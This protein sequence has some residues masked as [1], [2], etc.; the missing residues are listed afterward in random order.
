M[1]S[2]SKQTDRT[3]H[4]EIKVGDL[5]LNPDAR[6]RNTPSTKFGKVTKITPKG[7]TIYFGSTE[8]ELHVHTWELLPYKSVTSTKRAIWSV[9]PNMVFII[10]LTYDRFS[11][12]LRMSALNKE[13]ATS[14]FLFWFAKQYLEASSKEPTKT[15][16]RVVIHEIEDHIR[17]NPSS[18]DLTRIE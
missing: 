1:D 5:V 4:P 7:T 10:T 2:Y 9:M 3:N 12:T 14:N 16:I 11:R 13:Q 8:G 18:F 17:S 15:A 6:S